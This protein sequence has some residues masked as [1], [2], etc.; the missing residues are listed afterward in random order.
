MK[1]MRVV[2][3]SFIFL[4]LFPLKIYAANPYGWLDTV[5]NE[6][7]AGWAKDDDNARSLYVHIYVDGQF[8]KQVTANLYRSDV[9]GNYGFSWIIDKSFGPGPHRVNVYALGID[10]NGNLDGINPEL[11]GS[12]KSFTEAREFNLTSTDGT[13]RVVLDSKFGGAVTKIYDNLHFP[14]INLINN[15]QAGAMF[16][17]AF[18]LLPKHTSIPEGCAGNPDEW[19]DNPTQAG[20]MADGLAGNP[21]G[22]MGINTDVFDPSEFIRYEDNNKTVHLKS[23][24][25]RFDYCAYGNTP[26]AYRN[27]WDTNFYIEQ[28]ASIS[29]VYKNTLAVKSKIS[30]QGSDSREI[31]SGG[32]LQIIF[33]FYLPRVTYWKDG[34]QVILEREVNNENPIATDKNWAAL[35]GQNS[36]IGIGMVTAPE[37]RSDVYIGNFNYGIRNNSGIERLLTS[38]LYP[39]G[40]GTNLATYGKLTNVSVRSEPTYIWNYYGKLYHYTFNNTSSFEWYMYFPIGTV[41]MIKSEAEKILADPTLFGFPVPTPTPIPTSTPLPTHTPTPVLCEPLGNIDC[42]EKVNILDLSVL[43]SNFGSTSFITGDLNNNGKVD[44][45][46]L[47]ILLSNFGR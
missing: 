37:G 24:Y 2:L 16:Q 25:I 12:P 5:T 33:A 6:K 32:G 26:M 9:G 21:I 23:R 18:W 45:F 27:L 34:Y 30:Y 15:S 13:V 11:S 36:E 39:I 44:I 22:I 42:N 8:V 35:I 40:G 10:G 31:M 47:S 4:L 29:N 19:W 20:Y 1:D 28:W 17:S 41:P 38:V 43:L 14:N 7:I 46:D 3:L